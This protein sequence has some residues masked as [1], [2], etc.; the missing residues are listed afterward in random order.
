MGARQVGKTYAITRFGNENFNA[1]HTFNFEERPNLRAIFEYDLEIERII[2]ELSFL[3][4]KKIDPINDLIFF[5]EI[6]ACP[7]ALTALKYF[8]EKMPKLAVCSAG[9]ML[10]VTLSEESFPVGQV[11]FTYL[12]P[13]DFEE[14][15]LGCNLT[16]Q[17]QALQAIIKGEIR[18]ELVHEQLWRALKDYYVV[19]G[20]PKAVLQYAEN[21]KSDQTAFYQVRKVQS[22]IL[23]SYLADFSKHA[24]KINAVL[25]RSVFENIPI[26]ISIAIDES[27]GRYKFNQVTPAV[28]GYS[29]LKGPIDWL[30]NCALVNKTKIAKR[31]EYPLESFCEENIFKLYLFDIGILGCMFDLPASVIVNEDYGIAKGYFAENYVCQ[32]LASSSFE[33]RKFYSWAEGKSELEFIESISGTLVPV[34]AK[35]GKR[36]RAKS[37][38]SF[39]NRYHPELSV[40]ISARPLQYLAEQKLLHVPLYCAGHLAELCEGVLGRG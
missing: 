37:L 20:L 39:N 28:R 13:I 12:R 40:K 11:E 1:V 6:Q 24:G 32:A 7:R 23:S 21:I 3:S 36:L 14:F 9:S 27:V 8:R 34:E 29:K 16:K 15:L 5:D 17:H 22:D 38:A 30:V 25:I 31:N 19:G 35:A 4:E 10:G 2:K 26:Q 33:K 18:A